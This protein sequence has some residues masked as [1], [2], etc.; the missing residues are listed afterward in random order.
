MNTYY[1]SDESFINSNIFQDFIRKN[2]AKGNLRI[3]AYAASGAIPV[4]GVNIIISTMADEN[5]KI[6]FFEGVTNESGVIEK[7]SLPAPRLSS[8]NLIA[9]DKT[10][11]EIDAIYN[12]DNISAIYKVN[13]YEDVCV[14]PNINIVPELKVGGF[15]GR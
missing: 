4:A 12:P 14:Q 1:I 13:I 6:I 11:Y 5:T 8:D 7:I 2:P 10:E 9:P 15:N 3:R